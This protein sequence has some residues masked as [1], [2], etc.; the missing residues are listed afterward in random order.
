[1]LN[2]ALS[3][4]SRYPLHL[5]DAMVHDFAHDRGPVSLRWTNAPDHAAL[6]IEAEGIGRDRLYR[7]IEDTVE[8]APFEQ[9]IMSIDPAGD[10]AD[11]MGVCILKLLGGVIYVP[12]ITGIHGGGFRTENLV[13]V[14]K[15]AKE[16]G[17]RKIIP[18]K[19]Y[20]GGMFTSMLLSVMKEHY[21]EC[22]IEEFNSVGIKEHRICDTLEPVLNAHRV[23]F[24]AQALKDDLK[25]RAGVSADDQK[26]HRFLHQLT[27]ITRTPKC[28]VHD[29]LVDAF[30]MGVAVLTKHMAITT[31]SA[32]A[33]LKEQNAEELIQSWYKM[34][35]QRAPQPQ[36]RFGHAKVTQD[37]IKR[38]RAGVRMA[39]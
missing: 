28:L 3:D 39:R 16:H 2:A 10:G 5:A 23:V 33:K 13:R 22:G 11:A 27:R 29:D 7:A 6:D 9:S 21:P 14:C 12:L 30:A 20:G 37:F 17:V 38:Q 15:L 32:R 19:N 18:E 36:N 31:E 26:H 25:P 1:M 8:T 34:S 4:A 24:S 35:G